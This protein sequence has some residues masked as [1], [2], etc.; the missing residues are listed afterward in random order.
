MCRVDTPECFYKFSILEICLHML[1]KNADIRFWARISKVGTV[2]AVV[3]FAL[4]GEEV[5]L[6]VV[7]TPKNDLSEANASG[8]KRPNSASACIV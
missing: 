8:D 1:P 2:C 6:A 3:L 5:V 7:A 4:S